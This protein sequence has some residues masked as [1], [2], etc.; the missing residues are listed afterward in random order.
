MSTTRITAWTL[1]TAAGTGRQANLES[2]R[3]VRGG[4]RACDLQGVNLDT[5]IGRVPGLE[6]LPIEGALAP[7]DCRNNRLAALTLAQD[8]FETAVADAARRHGADRVA[9]L[10]GTSTSGVASTEDAFRRRDAHSG[11]LPGDYDY[12]HTQ[13]MFSLAHFTATRLGL[14]GPALVI[15]TACSSSAKVFADARRYLDAGLCDAAVVGGVD[16]LCQMTL[17]GFNALQLTAPDPCRPLDAN[18]AGISIGEAGGFFLLERQGS[19][20][21]LAGHGESSDAHHMSAP[22]PQGAG[23]ARA[24]AEALH[25]AGVAPDTVDYVLMHA[26]ATPSNDLAESRAL[27]QVFGAPV[28]AVGTKGLTGHTLGAA[29]AVNVAQALLSLEAGFIPGTAGLVQA[30]PALEL[31]TRDGAQEGPVRRVLV[32]AFGF[33]GN[34]CSLLLEAGP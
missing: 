29:G 23:A 14:C 7:F 1:T 18:R 19:G 10:L 32:N 3:T 9:V 15:S 25:R 31:N 22:H 26:T 24:M 30:D 20:P 27:K 12:R 4:L 6:D 2:L 11:E 8:G 5:G 17:Y 21:R 34:N 33:G 28:R 13:N 16:S